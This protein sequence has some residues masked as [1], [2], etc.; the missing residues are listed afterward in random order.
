MSSYIALDI[1]EKRIGVAIADT[2]APFPAPLV[3]LEVA[4]N[5]AAQLSTLLRQNA[6]TAVIVGYPRNQRGEPTAQTARVE[7]IV[8]LL[9]IPQH[10]A[11]YWQDESLTSVKAEA[12]LEKRKKLYAK[13]EVDSLAATYILN[14]FITSHAHATS[15]NVD[16]SEKKATAVPSESSAQSPKRKRLWL[17]VLGSL[18]ILGIISVGAVLAWYSRA[19]SPRTN[20]D[21]YSVV[22][23]AP[24]TGSAQIAQD[25]QAKK[26][27]KS[28]QA[29]SL[30]VRLHGF[31][32]LQAGEYRFSSHQ[33]VSDI[34]DSLAHGKVTT[35]NILIAPGLRLDQIEAILQKDGYSKTELEAAFIAVRDHPLLKGVP[36]SAKLE[37]YLFPDTY[38][39]GPSTTAEELVRLMLDT[40]QAKITPSITAG[41]TA[42]GLTVP[43]AI[44]LASVVQKEVSDSETQRTVA[45]VFLKRLKE[46]K[47]L[48]SDVTYMYAAAVTGQTASPELDSPY[49]TRRYTGLPPSA[50]ANFNLSALQAVANPTQTDYLFFVAGDDGVTH[51]SQTLEQHDVAVKQYCKKLCS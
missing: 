20:D 22:S 33:S 30:Y 13:G 42:Q 19:L 23:V 15:P 40:F 45:Q 6:V 31:N 14:D 32:T 26:V 50:I 8:K 34:V 25:L 16:D 38:K 17:K 9:N 7:H 43:Q 29:F 3:T 1:G 12:E 4:D 37:G 11:V 24:G 10:I 51:F 28:A 41:I 48:G 27:I 35:V 2:S 39:I 36:S 18:F 44:T 47:M 46:G 49:N 5:L 21:V